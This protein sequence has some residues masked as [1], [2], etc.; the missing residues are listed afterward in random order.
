MR[1]L[2]YGKGRAVPTARPCT[3]LGFRSARTGIL[4]ARPAREACPMRAH[5][6]PALPRNGWH[7]LTRDEPRQ[8]SH[9]HVLSSDGM[10]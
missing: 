6:A 7:E 5:C 9:L 3:V 2:G 1:T 4:A 10:P 8:A